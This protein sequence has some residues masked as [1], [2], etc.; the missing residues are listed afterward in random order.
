M[1]I[2]KNTKNFKKLIEI[3]IRFDDMLYDKI[4]KKNTII[5]M[6]NLKFMQKKFQ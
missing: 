5:R 3:L 1:R 6:K 4:I 2:E